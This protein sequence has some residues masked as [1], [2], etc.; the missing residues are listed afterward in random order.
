MSELVNYMSKMM[1]QFALNNGLWNSFFNISTRNFAFPV[2]PPKTD[3]PK[4][5]T[6]R[7]GVQ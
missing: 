3:E 2:F 5:S 7:E 6:S 4:D 1:S